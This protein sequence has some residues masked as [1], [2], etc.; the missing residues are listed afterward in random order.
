MKQNRV[1]EFDSKETILKKAR[2]YVAS[3]ETFFDEGERAI[4]VLLKALKPADRDLKRAIM[5]LLGSFAKEAVVWP[6]YDLMTDSSE[7]EEI[8]HDAAIQL[9]VVGPFLNNPQALANRLQEEI[10]RFRRRTETPRNLCD[11]M[12]RKLPGGDFPDRTAL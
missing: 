6:L 7:T 3:V 4:P 2:R 10:E 8:R 1:I 5:L 9:S 12:A 11:G